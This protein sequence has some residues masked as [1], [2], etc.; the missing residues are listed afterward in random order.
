MVYGK[1]YWPSF[2]TAEY[3]YNMSTIY[4]GTTTETISEYSAYGSIFKYCDIVLNNSH[5]TS[6]TNALLNYFNDLKSGIKPLP[7]TFYIPIGFGKMNRKPI[8]NTVETN[9]PKLIF[10]T[11]FNE[12]W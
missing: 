12:I 10:T 4:G 3:I 8:P 2:K 6:S 1:G 9:D 5:Y 7:F 11:E